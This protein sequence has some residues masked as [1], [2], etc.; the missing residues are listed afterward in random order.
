[1]KFEL[2]LVHLI[3]IPLP[4]PSSTPFSNHG[5][6]PDPLSHGVYDPRIRSA[7]EFS[8]N[9]AHLSPHPLYSFDSLP[10]D[11]GEREREKGERS[12]G[13]LDRASLTAGS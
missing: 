10:H 3:A 5:L 6:E 7:R 9:L 1:M 13:N 12:L 8:F 11:P 4:V 2:W